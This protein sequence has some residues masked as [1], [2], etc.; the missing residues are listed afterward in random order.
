MHR[1]C[2]PRRSSDDRLPKTLKD[3]I[4]RGGW[5]FTDFRPY[6]RWHMSSRF[7]FGHWKV[8]E[9]PAAPGPPDSA[10]EVTLGQVALPTKR[11]KKNVLFSDRTTDTSAVLVAVVVVLA[12]A[13]E[14]VEP[15]VGG[16]RGIPVHPEQTSGELVGARARGH[17]DLPGTAAGFGIGGSHND[18][19]F[20][21]EIRAYISCGRRADVV[22]AIADGNAVARRVELCQLPAGKVAALEPVAVFTRSRTLR[23]AKGRSRILYSG[24]TEPMEDDVVAI[25]VSGETLTST[26]CV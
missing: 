13:V 2:V 11:K 7:R 19:Y 21:D 6:R 26:D 17:G 14:V 25:N 5:G 3:A 1:G 15:G 9:D 10:R 8:T 24:R 22:P 20:V 4:R 16:E 18:L 12:G 23:V